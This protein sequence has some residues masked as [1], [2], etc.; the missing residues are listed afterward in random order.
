MAPTSLAGTQAAFMALLLKEDSPLPEGLDAE[1]VAIYRNAYRARLVDALRE[2]YPRT[3]RWVGDE[4]FRR[5]A[6]HHLIASP[7]NSWTLDEAGRGFADTLAALFRKDPEVTEL[8]WLEWA[9]HECFVSADATP[10]DAAGF[11][12]ATAQY[13]ESDWAR[14]RLHFLPG[15]QCTAL[16]HRIHAL[17]PLLAEDSP[18]EAARDGDYR[19]EQPI[20]CIVWRQALKPVFLPVSA[21]EGNTLSL[22]LTGASYGEACAALVHRLGEDAAV[23]EAG[24]MLGRW[25]HEGMIRAVDVAP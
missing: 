6:A 12:A 14:L 1:R 19:S 7:P 11:A 4:A 20:A 24:T 8:A 23:A 22:L 3:A 9:M 15:T 10:L 17:W 25:L 18:D 13:S 2:T 16:E 5:A 21:A